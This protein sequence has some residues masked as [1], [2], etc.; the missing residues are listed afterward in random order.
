MVIRLNDQHSTLAAI[1]TC[2]VVV[3]TAEHFAELYTL[4]KM[5]P[6][7]PRKLLLIQQQQH[8]LWWTDAS[9]E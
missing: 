2:L 8:T 1:T 9:P 3:E 4:K 7:R 6:T 5:Q